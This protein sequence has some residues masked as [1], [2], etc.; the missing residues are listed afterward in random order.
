MNTLDVK[1]A[2]SQ[3]RNRLADT[4]ED[5]ERMRR[6]PQRQAAATEQHHHQQHRGPT[7]AARSEPEVMRIELLGRFRLWVGLRLIEEDRWRLRK[8]RSLVKLLA[9]SRGHR[10]HR[11]QVMETLWPNLGIHKAS[12]NL[13]QILHTLRRSLEP[14]SPASS[15]AAA[16]TSSSYL[17]L[18]N[19]QLILCLDS[20]L[21]VDVE[22]FEE[23]AVTA[24]HA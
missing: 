9:L 15:S 1:G 21:W 10:L 24:R 4:P 17:L 5:R 19:E 3:E 11:E 12:N 6:R 20:P 23:A 18:R 16:S 14:S 22:A 7:R 2:E 8:A 13:H